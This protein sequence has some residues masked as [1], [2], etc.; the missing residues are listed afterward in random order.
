MP[1]C[2]NSA[3]LIALELLGFSNGSKHIC[4]PK[5]IPDI[6]IA[7][8]SDSN[9]FPRLDAYLASQISEIRYM[10]GEFGLEIQSYIDYAHARGITSSGR[11][12]LAMLSQRFRVDRVPGGTVTQQI[13]LAV[14][15]D[16]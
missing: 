13:L 1:Y 14:G 4:N 2:P 9:Q 3:L 12:I 6:I 16:G 15:L 11:A 8:Q 5:P 10:K 7:L